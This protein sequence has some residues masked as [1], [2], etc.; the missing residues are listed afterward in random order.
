MG[1]CRPKEI[2]Q[3]LTL[4]SEVFGRAGFIDRVLEV[5]AGRPLMSPPG[6]TRQELLELIA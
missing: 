2:R 1:W 5:A 3:V 4:P 6:P